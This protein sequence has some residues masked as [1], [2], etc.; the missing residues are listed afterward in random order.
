MRQERLFLASALAF[1]G[2]CATLVH[3]PY[4]DV[5]LDSNPPGA[6]AIVT[7]RAVA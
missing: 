5:R 4:Q 3:G 7:G 6:T 2:G 1:L